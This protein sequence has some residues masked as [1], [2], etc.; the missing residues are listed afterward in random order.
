MK[1]ELKL[2]NEWLE[3]AS[4][5]DVLS[6]LKSLDKEEDI[7]DRF[8][9][10]LSFGTGGL[11]GVI[12]AGTNR[13]NIYTI[14]KITKGLANH[15]NKNVK[16]VKKVAISYDSRIKSDLFARVCASVL[17]SENINVF[18][19]PH[20]M[21]V[22]SLSFATKYLGC[23]YG[24][25]I[26][27]SHNPSIYNGYK[28]Y[29]SD[30]NQITIDE[31]DSVL[32]EIN[33]VDTF[34]VKYND[35][36]SYLNTSIKYIDCSVIDTYINNTLKLSVLGNNTIK[37]A[38]IVY[39]PLNGSGMMCVNRVLKE[40]GFNN[41][42]V[43]KEQEHPDGTFKTCPYPN[44][45]IKEALSLAIELARKTDSD[46]V[47]ATDPDCDRVGI[48]VK[49]NNDYVLLTGNET[50]I[51]LFDFMCKMKIANNTMPKNPIAVKT[52]VT[53]D[54]LFS[55]AKKYG[56]EILD[57]LT[58]FKFIGEIICNL[59]KNNELE[60]YIYGM[61]ESY[62]YLTR[63]DVRDKD[64]VNAC[65]LISEMYEY[66]SKNNIN[67][68]DQLINL[69]KEFG[70][71]HSALDSYTF[72]GQSG[73]DTMKQMMEDIHNNKLSSVL[74][75]KI[76]KMYDYLNRYSVDNKGYKEAIT[77]PI[78]DVIKYKLEDGTTLVVRPSGTEPKIKFYF[79]TCLH[80]LND[81]VNLANKYQS[82]VKEF[83]NNYM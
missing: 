2:Y 46:L 57:V 43:V 80:T 3:K 59:E 18:I 30:G 78:S 73:S 79:T 7:I 9:Q 58:G 45:E 60:R 63:T 17:A 8:Y 10:E 22:P 44:P 26:T 70:F 64:A 76:I 71:Y 42:Y 24:I 53:T 74:P 33:N 69:Y 1:K 41:I 34:S 82:I 66:Y 65:L 29:G 72:K 5:F 12:G 13:I 25:M 15:I 37:N 83:V 23:S 6:E 31:A 55:V 4:D 14:A 52:I 40:D 75:V 16:G 28:V 61:E 20:L 49:Y 39:T 68:Y 48:A 50:G 27:A 77:L 11:R 47:L 67:L 35:F 56:V 38:K 19:Y 81:S 32:N 21:P 36:E 62:G 51:L 54:M